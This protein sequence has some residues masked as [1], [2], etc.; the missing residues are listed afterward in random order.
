MSSIFFSYSHKDE[1]L[2][3]QLETHLAML[4][5]QGLIDS[6]HD[7]RILAG[8]DLDHAINS[9]INTAD[10]ILLLVS[11]DF[12]ASRYCY[13]VEVRRAME[14]QQA[15][16]ARVIPVILRHCDW[17]SAPFGKLLAAPKDGRPIKAW[18][19]PDEAFADVAR[20]IRAALPKRPDPRTRREE[21]TSQS[22]EIARARSSNLRIRKEITEADRD[23][24]LHNSFE[25][26][27]E[28]FESSLAELENRHQ[29]IETAYRRIDNDRFSAV[30]YQNGKAVS[31]CKIA[32]GS[33]FGR[34]ISFSYNDQAAD[35][36]MNESLSVEMNDDR[37]YLKA[38]G[39]ASRRLDERL[40]TPE[41]AAEY[42]WSLLIEP[43]QR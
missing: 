39:M 34:G 8:D 38:L 4:R 31:R 3:D 13:D 21:T 40:L 5:N 30:I 24:F 2:R 7:R 9:Q 16:E 42:Y 11:P 43:L 14:R 29:E 19:D 23:R 41:G 20:Q 26:M 37:L 18:G 6:W 33:M 10:V 17:H 36:S 15:G 27:M 32:L 12:L 25:F 22:T 1:E 35:G 28:F